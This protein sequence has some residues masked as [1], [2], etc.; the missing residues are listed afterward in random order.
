MVYR[1]FAGYNIFSASLGGKYK[2]RRI[3][4]NRE[5]K[6]ITMISGC[7]T[8]EILRTYIQNGRTGTYGKGQCTLRFCR[9][10]ICKVHGNLHRFSCRRNRNIGH[11]RLELNTEYRCRYSAYRSYGC[12]YITGSV[13]RAEPVIIPCAVN[14]SRIRETSRCGFAYAFKRQR[15]G[16]R[17]CRTKYCCII[18]IKRRNFET[19][20]YAAA[21]H[22]VYRF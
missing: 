19:E 9:T 14:K 17:I 16:I 12:G 5:I 21:A 6:C 1:I 20:R 15:V 8:V 22:S 11:N 7:K 4:W 10:V 2:C 3:F 13:Y 18:N